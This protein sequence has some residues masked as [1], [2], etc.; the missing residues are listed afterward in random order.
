MKELETLLQPVLPDSAIKLA[1]ALFLLPL[2]SFLILYFGGKKLPRKGDIVA[3]C[4]MAVAAIISVTLFI[5]IYSGNDHYSRFTWFSL[6]S[7]SS[8]IQFTV[9]ILLNKVSVMMLVV[10]T[11]IS[12]MVHLYSFEYMEGKRNYLRYFP[13]LALFTFSMLGIVLSDNLLII[14]IFWEL[15]GFS[16][17]LLIGFW[18]EKESASKAAKKAFI[19]N[20]VGD[21]G[22]IAG[23][24]L[25]WSHFGTLELSVIKDL[26]LESESGEI[27]VLLAGL[28]IFC[29]TL[30]KSAQFPLMA[31][32]PDAMEGPTPVSALIHAATMVAAGVYLLFKAF[33]LL[34]IPTLNIIA[35]I[36]AITCLMGAIPALTQTD[37]KKVLAYSTISQLGY[38]VM[39]MGVGAYDAALFHLLTHA[40]FKAC[41][42]L[43]AGAVIHEMHHIQKDMFNRGDFFE[44]STLDMRMMG[45][46]RKR[47][48]LTFLAY[49]I[50][51]LSLIG[52][53]LFSG[54]LSKDA[55]LI[56]TMDWASLQGSF[57]AY[58]IPLAGL[59]TVFLTAYY[60]GRQIFM[61]FFG[62][63]RLGKIFKPAFKAFDHASD[64]GIFMRIPLICL[65]SLSLFPVFSINPFNASGSWFMENV[66]APG[67]HAILI[68]HYIIPFLTI[69]LGGLGLILSWKKFNHYNVT[70]NAETQKGF[71]YALSREN[72]FQDRAFRFVIEKPILY[73]SQKLHQTDNK[74]I[75]GLLHGFVILQV[76]VAHILSFTD[77]YMVDG[78]VNFSA[79]LSGK[80]GGATRS[81][82]KGGI[83]QYVFLLALMVIAALCFIII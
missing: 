2:I 17:Y 11:F 66:M 64:P 19:F 54:F 38:M 15:V 47:M 32:L 46:L 78:L 67:N 60:M 68:N 73:L 56:K 34:N 20:R 45:G 6:E 10:V 13:Y 8:P 33:F 83:Q 53:P 31:W 72:F 80:T 23:L 7:F 40:F 62:E 81:W 35:A 58:L 16:S 26:W 30:G 41:L 29:G 82:Q 4:I 63:F 75:D 52:M 3:S 44:F 22:F 14:F 1:L 12:L 57:W 61:V 28:G 59:L 65:A 5:K 37:I 43:S 50:S 69:A 70:P 18:F 21:F 42:F 74:I 24:L 48:P 76:I 51:T 49:A 39:A 55:I 25:L 77:K 71:W 36:G 79:K 27:W 9:S